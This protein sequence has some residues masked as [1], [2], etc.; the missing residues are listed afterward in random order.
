MAFFRTRKMSKITEMSL[1]LVP[2]EEGG[3]VR[4]P[5]DPLLKALWHLVK[6]PQV[7]REMGQLRAQ[8]LVQAVNLAP[9]GSSHRLVPHSGQ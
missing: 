6:E 8:E 5:R 9:P 7:C 1:P 4:M 2:L 3:A